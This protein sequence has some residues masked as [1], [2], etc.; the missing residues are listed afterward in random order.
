[1]NGLPLEF[2]ERM[3]QMLGEE[4]DAFLRS[5]EEKP[6]PWAPH[7]YYY[8]PLKRPGKNPLHEA[9]AYYIQE[10]SAM[11]VAALSGVRPRMAKIRFMRPEHIIYR[12][13]AP[14]LSRLSRGSDPA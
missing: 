10:P 4:Y 12:N 6:I 5:Y 8:D 14:W 1:M 2:K 9:G 13:Q 11:A 3:K 7:G